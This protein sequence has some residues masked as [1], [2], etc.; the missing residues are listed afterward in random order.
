M[1]DGNTE[2]TE[3]ILS[4]AIDV[5]RQLGPGL[6]ESVYESALSIELRYR[7]IPFKRQVGFPLYYRDELISEHRPDLIVED[8]VIVE[9]KTVERF[10]PIH[11][12]QMLTYLRVTSLQLGLLLNFN[13]ETM[14]AGI[15]RVVLKA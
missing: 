3:K 10:A 14:K 12:A 8:T 15:R 9:V 13:S 7:G 2:I 11:T 5:H 1:L 4:C 6:L